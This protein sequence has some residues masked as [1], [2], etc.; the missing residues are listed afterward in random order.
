[1][2]IARGQPG[3]TRGGAC[4]APPQLKAFIR[5]NQIE[6]GRPQLLYWL[7]VLYKERGDF[8]QG[9]RA[10]AEAAALAPDYGEAWCHLAE[11]YYLTDRKDLARGTF[12]RALAAEANSAMVHARA[13]RFFEAT[14]DIDRARALLSDAMRLDPKNEVARISALELDLE[15]RRYE[16]AIAAAEPLLA[17]GPGAN[18]RNQ[19][20]LN[21]IAAT[22]F[23]RLGDYASAFAR[24]AEA[25]RLQAAL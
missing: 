8:A 15:D 2:G 13:A 4:A 5:A 1:M 23:D 20:R 19:S 9:E 14:H 21:H 12:E 22:A 6:P 25:N 3:C 24:Y 10:F 18:L 7:G 16:A 17:T 11:I